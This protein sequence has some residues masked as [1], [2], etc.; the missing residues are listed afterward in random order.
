MSRILYI[1]V[2]KK[3]GNSRATVHFKLFP[4]V[5]NNYAIDGLYYNF[6]YRFASPPPPQP[7]GLSRS[8]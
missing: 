1:H 4:I 8:V 6:L 7:G 2:V 3:H 5:Y